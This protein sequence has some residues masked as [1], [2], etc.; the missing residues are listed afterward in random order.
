MLII[1]QPQMA[2]LSLNRE[3]RFVEALARHSRR[4][5]PRAAAALGGGLE[6]ALLEIAGRAE[7]H[8]FRTQRQV[9]RYLNLVFTFGL[10][11]DRSSQTRWAARILE[12]SL[13]PAA[14]LDRLY[15]VALQH[16]SEGRG[17]FAPREEP[18]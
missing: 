2:A 10:D 7:S 8:G 16:E 17:Y 4:F 5:F 15:A 13:P 3:R 6:D 9:A 14:K 1:R 12:S 18:R 11:F